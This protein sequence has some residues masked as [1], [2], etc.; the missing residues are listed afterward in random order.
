MAARITHRS[1]AM[2]TVSGPTVV[3]ELVAEL[4]HDDDAEH[5]DIAIAHESGWSLS[6][7]TGG[8]VVWENVDEG[9]P[10]HM[11]GLS[12][13]QVT[14][15][16]RRRGCQLTGCGGGAAVGAGIRRV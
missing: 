1:G 11:A 6:A 10:R 16:L 8:L 4:D 13:D 7:F 12:R 9:E 5:P 14:Q 2:E 15:S 3:A